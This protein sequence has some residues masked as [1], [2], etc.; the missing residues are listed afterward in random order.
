[1]RGSSPCLFSPFDSFL[2]LIS[3]SG[4]KIIEILKKNPKKD[5]DGYDEGKPT[6]LFFFVRKRNLE[7]RGKS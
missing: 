4:R 3:F 2:K 5:P 1:M 6:F 7:E